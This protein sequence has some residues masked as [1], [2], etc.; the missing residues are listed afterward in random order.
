LETW[1]IT[2]ISDEWRL[3]VGMEELRRGQMTSGIAQLKEAAKT[4]KTGKVMLAGV[5]SHF[6]ADSEAERILVTELKIQNAQWRTLTWLLRRLS[7]KVRTEIRK[8]HAQWNGD[9]VDATKRLIETGKLEDL[10][11]Y[12]DSAENS[13]ISWS[14]LRAKLLD[15]EDAIF[16]GNFKTDVV[17]SDLQDIASI[18]IQKIFDDRDFAPLNPFSRGVTLFSNW[19]LANSFLLEDIRSSL[20]IFQALAHINTK[21]APPRTGHPAVLALLQALCE[22]ASSQHLE[23][24]AA[25]LCEQCLDDAE[26]AVLFA[27]LQL[28][29]ERIPKKSELRTTAFRSLCSSVMQHSKLAPLPD[30]ASGAD[31]DVHASREET[32]Q[33]RAKRLEKLRMLA[34]SLR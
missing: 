33:G 7:A 29:G 23:T 17:A 6:G 28:L 11:M 16:D 32:V 21:F 12:R 3:I 19:F 4:S 14:A 15:L 26:A 5:L 18:D 34:K 8:Y 24:A 20:E 1:R 31:A 25:S 27:C 10:P 22:P 30:L 2:I 13:Q 9:L